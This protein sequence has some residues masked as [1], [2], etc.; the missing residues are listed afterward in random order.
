MCPNSCCSSKNEERFRAELAHRVANS[1][2][3]EV[4]KISSL[5]KSD[6]SWLRRDVQQRLTEARNEL[7]ENFERFFPELQA[8]KSVNDFFTDS[9]YYLNAGQNDLDPVLF[10]R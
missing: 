1:T 10:G 7:N 3:S 9:L 6:L 5:A 2:Q 8:N 4:R